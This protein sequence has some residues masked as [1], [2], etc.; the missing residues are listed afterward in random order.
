VHAETAVAGK[1]TSIDCVRCNLCVEACPHGALAYSAQG[2]EPERGFRPLPVLR[3]GPAARG[4]TLAEEV[5]VL[6]VAVLSFLAADLVWGGH[7]LAAC[8]ALAEGFLA[9]IVLRLLRRRDVSL[10]RVQ[11]RAG[12]A[13]RLSGISAVAL[14]LL[15]LVPIAQAAA[16]KH[17]R[18][19]GLGLWRATVTEEAAAL[20]G[21]TAV[22]LSAGQRV[23]LHD[24]AESLERAVSLVPFHL[25]TREALCHLY[26]ALG[27]SRAR[28][29][30]EELLRR[31]GPSPERE[32]LLRD[33][34][35]STGDLKRAQWI[36]S[37]AAAE[38]KRRER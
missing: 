31:G 2:L 3:A 17:W 36:D 23:R 21:K 7:F 13:W 24:A 28:P 38:L 37:R 14:F 11:L 18:G 20:E 1:V 25:S 30:A 10:G 19:R 12:G 8:L 26:L 33:A 6:A 29:H 4:I 32:A 22:R 15:T 16:F 35:L 27:D 9:L 34:Y 5:F